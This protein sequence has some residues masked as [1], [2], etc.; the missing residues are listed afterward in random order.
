MNFKKIQISAQNLKVLT[1]SF[2]VNHKFVTKTDSNSVFHDH[3]AH[4][5][6]QLYIIVLYI[7]FM[8][9][10]KNL[11]FGLKSKGAR[12]RFSRKRPVCDKN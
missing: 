2:T 11:N 5:S 7:N 8:N 12:L 6:N 1:F 3:E 10:K 4:I 9:F